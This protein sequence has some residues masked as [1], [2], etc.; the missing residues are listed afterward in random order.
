MKT[1]KWDETSSGSTSGTVVVKLWDIA[2]QESYS[3]LSRVY[4]RGAHACIIVFDRQDP[5]P[6]AEISS[7]KKDLDLKVVL[8][9]GSPVPCIL[10]AN[11]CD[12]SAK[13]VP[14]EDIQAYVDN[15][16]GFLGWCKVSARRDKNI[17]QSIL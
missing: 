4:Y 12:M 1:I 8:S 3:A 14:D 10:F 17:A 16:K 13:P 11:K 5:S 6:F 2:G 15:D 9:N 7:R